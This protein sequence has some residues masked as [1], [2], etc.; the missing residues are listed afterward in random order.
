MESTCKNLFTKLE[1]S[2]YTLFTLRVNTDNEIF[3]ISTNF[4]G[5]LFGVQPTIIDRII[6]LDEKWDHQSF[7][8]KV[9]TSALS[10]HPLKKEVPMI[11]IVQHYKR[12]YETV[13]NR[14]IQIGEI[15]PIHTEDTP[16]Y[17]ATKHHI[18]T[19]YTPEKFK[20]FTEVAYN[21]N[22]E[23]FITFSRNPADWMPTNHSCDPNTIFGDNFSFNQVVCRLI[24]KGEPIALDYATFATTAAAPFDCECGEERCRKSFKGDDYLTYSQQYGTGVSYHVWEK[25]LRVEAQQQKK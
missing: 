16:F 11:K 21:M 17:M 25:R 2:S 6:E 19:T 22:D 10:K 12:G 4:N 5:T 24:K 23:V 8:S 1:L 9:I 13:A 3:I 15:I 14:D 20:V 18:E 7:I